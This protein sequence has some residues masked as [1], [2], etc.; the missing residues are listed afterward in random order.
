MLKTNS[1]LKLLFLQNLKLGLKIQ[2][3]R[4]RKDKNLKKLHENK[5]LYM[6]KKNIHMKREIE[7]INDFDNLFSIE[8][9]INEKLK[10]LKLRNN[11]KKLSKRN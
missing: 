1:I 11:K 10:I 5:F 9:P 3:E 4:K 2:K 6:K 7:M 8:K